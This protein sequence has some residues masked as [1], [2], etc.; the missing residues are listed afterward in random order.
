VL[1]KAQQVTALY[2]KVLVVGM[3]C[4]CI[5][6]SGETQVVQV[7][8]SRNFYKHRHGDEWDGIRTGC[9]RDCQSFSRWFELL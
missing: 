6:T 8:S 5:E 2:H 4:I 9:S 1:I 3:G 7:E